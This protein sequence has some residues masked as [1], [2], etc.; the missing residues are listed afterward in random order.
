MPSRVQVRS[1]EVCGSGWARSETHPVVLAS[2]L[3]RAPPPLPCS[4]CVCGREQHQQR[5]L[6]EEGYALTL[7]SLDHILRPLTQH[8]HDLCTC[9][10]TCLGDLL[11][12]DMLP[13]VMAILA[14]W[15]NTASAS[16]L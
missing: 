8:L 6:K 16:A 7:N 1:N 13:V 10:L 5:G 9:I 2:G 3:P 11:R 12:G 14:T 4:T 15:R